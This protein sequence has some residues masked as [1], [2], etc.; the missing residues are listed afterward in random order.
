MLLFETR[1]QK[2]KLMVVGQIIQIFAAAIASQIFV[3]L[4][5]MT[6]YAKSL[7]KHGKNSIK[8]FVR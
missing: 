3:L 7:Q 1:I 4:C 8:S 5:L 6:I 2:T